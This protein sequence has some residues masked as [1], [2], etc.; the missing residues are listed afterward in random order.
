MLISPPFLP[1]RGNLTEEQWLDAAMPGGVPGAGAYPLSAQLDWHGGVH[2]MAPM[3]GVVPEPICAIADGTVVFVRE[4][5]DAN[6]PNDPLNYGGGYTSNGVVV[7]RHDTEI[8]VN[9]QGQA[10]AVRFYSIYQHLYSIRPAVITGRAIWRKDVIGQ[11]GHIYGAPNVFHMEIRCDEANLQRLIGRIDGDVPLTQDG[12]T[13]VVFGEAYFVLPVET[14]VYGER[15]LPDSPVARIR[16]P[17][18]T[19]PP[20]PPVALQP[21]AH[22]GET[23]VVGL[24]YAEGS[25]AA[26]QRGHAFVTGYRLDGSAYG[27]SLIEAEAEYRLYEDCKAI[28][29]SYPENSQPSCSVLMEVLRFG[30]AIGPDVLNPANVPHWRQIR[31]AGGTGW[32]NLNA[33]NVRKYSDADFPQWKGWRLINDDVD[34]D[35]R[36][37]SPTLMS[38]LDQNGD[39]NINIAEGVAALAQ[40]NIAARMRKTICRIPSE[41]DEATLDAQWIWLRTSTDRHPNAMSAADYELFS[42]HVR[43]QCI[44]LSELF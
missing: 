44:P 15:P 23:M 8:G 38:W 18:N 34:R 1:A 39:G 41:W 5:T 11:A 30:R 12:R 26:G 42:A 4:R 6:G 10:T 36:C 2:L 27:E 35:G 24:R 9:A 25:G 19:Q 40:E 43:A 14:P 33:A 7:I 21:V 20:P 3:N 13:D 22:I 31:Y 37:D 32:V 28:S 29:R 16:P 17:G